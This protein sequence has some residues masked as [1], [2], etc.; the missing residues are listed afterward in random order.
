VGIWGSISLFKKGPLVILAK[1]AQMNSR[2][3]IKEILY[4]NAVPFY[5]QLVEEYGDALWQQDGAPYHTSGITT[6]YLKALYT[7]DVC[8]SR[9]I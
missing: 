6:A 9:G 7:S 8:Q 4:P 5:D 1:G 3:Y 2:C